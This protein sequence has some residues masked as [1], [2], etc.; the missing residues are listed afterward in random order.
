MCVEMAPLK[1]TNMMKKQVTIDEGSNTM[2]SVAK[3]VRP[4]TTLDLSMVQELVPS[5]RLEASEK[6]IRLSEPVD[7]FG[8]FSQ[9]LS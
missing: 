1:Q 4:P 9:N 5:G 8:C 7:T 3:S 6:L 2:M